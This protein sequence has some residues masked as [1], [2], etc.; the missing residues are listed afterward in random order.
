MKQRNIFYSLL[1]CAL[2]LAGCTKEGG[3]MRLRAS[4]ESFAKDSK[5]AIAQ[6]GTYNTFFP[7]LADGEEVDI[8]G[9]TYQIR[10]NA[11]DVCMEITPDAPMP[12]PGNYYIAQMPTNLIEENYNGY[13]P[14][15]EENQ[16]HLLLNYPTAYHMR[17]LT[18]SNAYNYNYYGDPAVYY[19][20]LPLLAI[21]DRERQGLY[22]KNLTTIIDVQVK[23][24]LG[25]NYGDITL[26][27]VTV[28][29]CDPLRRDIAYYLGDDT[30][31]PNDDYIDFFQATPSEDVNVYPHLSSNTIAPNTTM[32]VPVPV[33]PTS[34]NATDPNPP[35]IRIEVKGRVTETSTG[36]LYRF[37]YAR[38]R[39]LS[40]HLVRNQY[41]TAAMY[42]S[43]NQYM[44]EWTQIGGPID[45]GTGNHEGFTNGGNLW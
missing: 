26:E 32:H 14:G 6:Y 18:A 10:F 15:T 16:F 45:P 24:N 40:K 41:F 13:T 36:K 39:A 27:Q 11:E 4:V 20:N 44:T 12:E 34:T 17:P 37:T 9:S 30:E 29:G 23:N 2:L 19:D 28:P 22:F 25:S 8:N 1:A 35:T 5:A 42:V 31:D 38:E 43:N 21:S 7:V 3:R 33:P